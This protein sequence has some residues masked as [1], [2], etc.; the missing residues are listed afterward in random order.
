M[1]AE[2]KKLEHDLGIPTFFCD[3]HSPWQRGSIKN[4]NGILRR[5]L[6]RKKEFTDYSEQDIQDSVWANQ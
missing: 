4:V 5:D 2:H 1:F 6:P 3:P